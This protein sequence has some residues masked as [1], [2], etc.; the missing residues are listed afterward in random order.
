MI[1]EKRLCLYD[2]DAQNLLRGGCGVI[3]AV[4][5]NCVSSVLLQAE[6]KEKQIKQKHIAGK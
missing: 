4:D 3:I 5:T 6:A 2:W 1:L